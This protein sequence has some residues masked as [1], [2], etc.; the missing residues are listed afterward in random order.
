MT[1][2]HNEFTRKR[3]YQGIPIYNSYST[4]IIKENQVI[5]KTSSENFNISL[6][7]A[8]ISPA[9]SMDDALNKAAQFEGLKVLSN[10]N[11]TQ[12]GI[13]FST[14]ESAELVYYINE[15][16]QAILSYTFSYQLVKENQNDII[17]VVI[18][19]MNGEIIEKDIK[20]L[21]FINL[22][23]RKVTYVN[24]GNQLKVL[25]YNGKIKWYQRISQ[26][27]MDGS[28]S[29]HDYLVNDQNEVFP[30]GMFNHRKNQLSKAIADHPE[31]L[32]EIENQRMD[33][34][35]LL[36]ILTRYNNST[37]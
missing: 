30:L 1:T 14:E 37:L 13:Y 21:S 27:M 26:H 12:E 19:A 35:D 24:D 11:S 9:L 32:K 5:S 16:N 22:Y 33:N 10:T 29:Y 23:D 31:L 36:D 7:N 6:N 17:H 25:V 4:Y 20:S 18:N 8:N 15:D 28:I 2:P 34:I 3:T